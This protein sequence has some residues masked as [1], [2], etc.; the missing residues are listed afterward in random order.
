MEYNGNSH[1]EIYKM[2]GRGKETEMKKSHLQERQTI[3]S[4]GGFLELE[5]YLVEE[6][7]KSQAIYGIG[8]KKKHSFQGKLRFE[9]EETGGLSAKKETV[10]QLIEMLARNYIT[11][12]CLNEVVDDYL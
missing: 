12:M 11:P 7:T 9:N 10:L 6:E 3:E 4:E 2:L 5:Y 8:V 1:S